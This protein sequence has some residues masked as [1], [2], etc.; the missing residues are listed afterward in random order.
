MA[1]P[2]AVQQVHVACTM[3]GLLKGTAP[4]FHGPALASGSSHI[5]GVRSEALRFAPRYGRPRLL[6]GH[7]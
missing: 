1:V 4:E 6:L 2:A 5:A 7:L 3:A